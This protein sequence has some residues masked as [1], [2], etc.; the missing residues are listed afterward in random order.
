MFLTHIYNRLFA[1][2]K[3][4]S[5]FYILRQSSDFLE[6]FKTCK[7]NSYLN[8]LVYFLYYNE[9]IVPKTPYFYYRD[10]ALMDIVFTAE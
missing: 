7:E 2:D 5:Y 8:L 6:R 3:R 1:S 10:G 4:I 9:G